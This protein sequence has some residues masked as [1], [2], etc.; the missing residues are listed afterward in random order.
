MEELDTFDIINLLNR[1]K[2]KF[3]ALLAQDL[4]DMYDKNSPEFIKL[5]KL[6]FDYFNDYV[7]SITRMFFDNSIE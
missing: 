7:R 3:C 2:G 4:E 1:K 5:K 6:F